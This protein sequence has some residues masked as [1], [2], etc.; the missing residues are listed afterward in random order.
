MIHH[1]FPHTEHDIKVMLE[2]C[3]LKSV[4]ELYS[5]VP[6]SLLLGRDYNLPES[7]SETE[8]RNFFNELNGKNKVLKCFAGGG[9][10][11]HYT[12]AVIPYIISRSEFLT[13][14]TPYHP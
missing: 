2:R 9:Y 12:P 13:A 11:D 3:G 10:Y 1:Y 6:D 14:Y 4:D 5:D 8:V 7:M